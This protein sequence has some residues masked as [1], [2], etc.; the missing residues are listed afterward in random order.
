[1]SEFPRSPFSGLAWKPDSQCG[2][3]RSRS[4]Y[5]ANFSFDFFLTLLFVD[6][7]SSHLT[8]F[9]VDVVFQLKFFFVTAGSSPLPEVVTPP[10][11]RN[12]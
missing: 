10:R 7:A 2:D 3:P 4:P 8:P 12:A 5:V 6:A 1:M 9:R 11:F